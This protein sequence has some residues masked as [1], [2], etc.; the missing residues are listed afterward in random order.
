LA[1]GDGGHAYESL[2]Q[3]FGKGVGACLRIAASVIPTL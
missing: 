2:S 1:D 3:P